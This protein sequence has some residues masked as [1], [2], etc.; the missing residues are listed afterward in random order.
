MFRIEHE[1]TSTLPRLRYGLVLRF[2]LHRKKPLVNLA[3]AFGDRILDER[4]AQLAGGDFAR[5][6]LTPELLVGASGGFDGADF[7]RRHAL[8][9]QVADAAG[10]DGVASREKA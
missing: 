8:H 1:S 5:F 9:T 6:P 7:R 4:L 3:F 10:A 2:L